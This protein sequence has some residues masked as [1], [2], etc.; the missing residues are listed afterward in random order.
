M[1]FY[2]YQLAYSREAIQGMLAKPSNRKAAAVK[3][4]KAA[5]GKCHEFFFAFGKYDAITLI[6]APDDKT[7]MAI[8]GAVG[9]SG[10]IAAGATTKLM[11]AEEA[12]AAMT[13]AGKV[14]KSYSPPMAK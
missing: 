3:V 12:M 9:A 14:T 6:E 4:I 5:G 1:A 2:L 13:M 8:A 10:T 11:T 7:M